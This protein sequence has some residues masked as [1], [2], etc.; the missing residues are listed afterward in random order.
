[1]ATIEQFV[2]VLIVPTAKLNFFGLKT[3]S[4]LCVHDIQHEYHPEL[5]TFAKRVIRWGAYR[6]SCWKAT[7]VQASSMYI[8]NCLLEKFTFLDPRKIFL[9]PEGVDLN[10][11][12]TAS[13][14]ERPPAIGELRAESFVFYPAQLWPH[15]NHLLLVDALAIF[16]DRT[17]VE[18]PC[19]LTGYDY[20][21]WQRVQERA[22]EHGLKHVY[23]LGRVRFPEMLWLYRNC[24]GVLAL[25]FHESSS[26][27]VRE[28]AVFGKPLI[29]ANIP[30]NVETR[31]F[32][33]L[34]LFDKD[35]AVDL[36]NALSELLD[37]GSAL[38]R[39]SCENANIVK[40]FD[41]A[42]IAETYLA[43]ARSLIPAQPA[44]NASE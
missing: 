25:G 44:R 11:F 33:H 2:D 15:K 36:A 39:D 40:I 42:S 21:H 19:V 35:N 37:P 41:W 43:T 27:P 5:F 34:R 22:G 28:G 1:M 3:P 30:P 18:L 4:I 8:R 31:Q 32:L 23:F 16:R 24:R 38:S 26:L 29:C 14:V 12:S 7:A 13:P 17:G 10:D 6:A 20:G 9:A